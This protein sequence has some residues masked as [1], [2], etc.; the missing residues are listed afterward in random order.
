MFTLQ[1][2][3]SLQPINLYHLMQLRTIVF[4]ILEKIKFSIKVDI[5]GI[6]SYTEQDF[7]D[8]CILILL[9]FTVY[10]FYSTE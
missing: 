4:F 1:L 9:V 8:V 7:I 6:D 5:L 10:I 2:L 3:V